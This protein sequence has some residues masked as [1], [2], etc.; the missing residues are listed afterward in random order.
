[1]K[2]IRHGTQKS[3]ND[4]SQET[5]TYQWP[6]DW[7]ILRK[8]FVGVFHMPIVDF[9]DP[10]LSWVSGKF[11]IDIVKFDDDMHRKFGEYEDQGLSMKD[12]IKQHYGDA[13]LNLIEQL[14]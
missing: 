10:L 5:A 6:K 14:I 4:M 1:M 8:N 13:G 9:Y 12:I 2:A 7:A 3:R 11:M